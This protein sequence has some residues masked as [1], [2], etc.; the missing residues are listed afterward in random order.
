MGICRV[1]MVGVDCLRNLVVFS[2]FPTA[3]LLLL[4]M[5]PLM[6]SSHGSCSIERL[7]SRLIFRG[8]IL[9]VRPP[10]LA[11]GG[12]GGS[13]SRRL[14]WRAPSSDRLGVAAGRRRACVTPF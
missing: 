12:D 1:H 5:S 3:L 2:A 14:R 9:T 7:R 4:L 8:L 11:G 6:L 13:K 10:P